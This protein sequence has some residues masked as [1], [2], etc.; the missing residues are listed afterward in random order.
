M[1]PTFFFFFITLLVTLVA[2]A[3]L[4]IQ[5]D[6]DLAPKIKDGK[7]KGSG[8][9]LFSSYVDMKK[10]PSH[11]QLVKMAE[12]A[13]KEVTNV[14]KQKK[15]PNFMIPPV[16]TALAVDNQVFLA[17]S[18]KGDKYVYKSKN[19]QVVTFSDHIKDVDEAK[20]LRDAMETCM[21]NAADG[22]ETKLKQHRAKGN[23]GE[24]MD[25]YTWLL[26]HGGKQLKNKTPKPLIV[27]WNRERNQIAK[28][29][30]QGGEGDWGCKDFVGVKGMDFDVVP[31]KTKGAAYD[32]I[33]EEKHHQKL[34]VK[35][36]N[37]GQEDEGKDDD[38][39][40]EAEQPQKQGKGGSK[41]EVRFEA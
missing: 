16:M 31:A 2:A 15:V 29:C 23:C 6:E 4:G 18:L 40:C 11:E 20:Q 32:E 5:L 39:E 17:S 13:G 35:N 38:Q 41:R 1:L 22:D 26:V 12:D 28:P 37:K 36:P 14:A 19:K 7:R 33:V 21:R 25:A 3:D 30:S 9:Y 27:A 10:A 24:V 8:W 34:P